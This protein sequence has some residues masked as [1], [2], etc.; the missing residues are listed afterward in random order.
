MGKTI[1]RQATRKKQTSKKFLKSTIT[2]RE[3]RNEIRRV[4]R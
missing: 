2:E 4:F 3:S 1:R